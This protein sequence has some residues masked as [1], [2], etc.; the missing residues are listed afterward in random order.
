MEHR[1]TVILKKVLSELRVAQEML[2]SSSFAD[3]ESNE[4]LKRAICMTVI[5]IGNLRRISRTI[6]GGQIERS[7]YDQLENI[8]SL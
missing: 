7:L 5:N 2:G 3:F 1:D 4:M 6:A 8:I